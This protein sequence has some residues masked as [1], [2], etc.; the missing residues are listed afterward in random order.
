MDRAVLKVGELARRT[1]LSVRALHYYDEI[2]LLSPSQHNASGHRLY[3]AA[4]IERL[5]QIK[6]LRQLGLSLAEIKCCLDGADFSL[7]RA[8]E[9]NIARLEEQI[10][11]QR[12]LSVRM[13]RMRDKLRRSEEVSV[14]ELVETIGEMINMEK[15][16]TVEQLEQLKERRAEIGEEQI[17]QVEEEWN[18][19]IEEVRV[20]IG[21]GTDPTSDGVKAIARRW[22]DLSRTTVEGFTGGDAG[23]RESLSAFQRDD[24]TFGGRIDR[25]V[26]E[27]IG[28]ALAALQSPE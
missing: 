2:G 20:E 22:L 16:Y 28:A 13:Q 15:F 14:G 11:T 23:I 25:E 26:V 9:L 27:Y 17:R 4:E 18:E 1:G 19:L 24:P 6:S 21:R 3:T 10:E 12:R 7:E 8:M 5:Q